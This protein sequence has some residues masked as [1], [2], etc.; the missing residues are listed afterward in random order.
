MRIDKDKRLMVKETTMDMSNSN[1]MQ[2]IARHY[3]PNAI[4]TIDR[5]HIPKQT[6]DAL[7]QMRV[8]H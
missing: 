8:A 1:Y 3:F 6:C 7:L 5:F 4:R 2:L